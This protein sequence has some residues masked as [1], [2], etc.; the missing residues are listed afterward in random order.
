M[1]GGLA[2]D[3]G[4][5]T[6]LIYRFFVRPEGAWRGDEGGME[7]KLPV[8]SCEL[9][10]GRSVRFCAFLCDLWQGGEGRRGIFVGRGD[11]RFCS[12]LFSAKGGTS[13]WGLHGFDSFRHAFHS[14]VQTFA[15]FEHAATWVFGLVFKVT[16]DF[17]RR[18]RVWW[19]TRAVTVP[20][21][22]MHT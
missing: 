7:G 17:E 5:N 3:W 11:V 19:Y 16:P 10:V 22:P 21:P 15:W 4:R 14:A 2:G 9:P 12:V 6:P 1:G 20:N 18:L 8:A 13:C